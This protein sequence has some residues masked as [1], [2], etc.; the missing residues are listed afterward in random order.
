M[1]KAYIGIQDARLLSGRLDVRHRRLEDEVLIQS[2]VESLKVE[3]ES[4]PL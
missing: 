3:I 1:G 2:A 4:V